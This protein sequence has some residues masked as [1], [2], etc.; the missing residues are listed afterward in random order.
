V[1]SPCGSVVSLWKCCLTVP[2][3]SCIVAGVHGEG[4]ALPL[5]VMLNGVSAEQHHISHQREKSAHITT[6]AGCCI[7][8]CHTL[9]GAS[10]PEGGRGAGGIL[11]YTERHYTTGT[12]NPTTHKPEWNLLL[13]AKC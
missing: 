5:R 12:A 10:N 11:W 1:L 9:C 8:M 13:S 7:Y 4:E 6:G 2:M 3:H